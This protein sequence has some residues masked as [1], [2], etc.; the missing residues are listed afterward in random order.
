MLLYYSH[1]KL[2]VISIITKLAELFGLFSTVAS[3]STVSTATTFLTTPSLTSA[4]T[5]FHSKTEHV[6]RT[7]SNTT[8][9]YF[10]VSQRTVQPANLTSTQNTE[11]DQQESTS[12]T[13]VRDTCL[14]VG[15]A[16]LAA[17]IIALLIVKRRRSL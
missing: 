3:N 15:V 17:V 8:F 1:T 2:A 10:S 11:V 7:T 9:F 5:V 13:L 12:S 16:L 6:S 4:T 14:G